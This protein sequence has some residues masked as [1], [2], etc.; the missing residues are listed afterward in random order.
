[1]RAITLDGFER[2]FAADPDP[3]QT[4]R[5]RDEA[6]KRQAILHAIG[7]GPLGRILELAA[8][9]GSNS[10]AV[11]PRA[12][13]LDA[14]EATAA[15]TTLVAKALAGTARARAI[16]LAVPARL[17]RATY[18]GVVV[19]ELLYYLSPRAMRRTA[20]D[21]A[22]VLRPGGTLVL[23]HHRIDFHDF[24]QHAAPLHRQFLHATGCDWRVRPVH[25]NRR[26]AVLACIRA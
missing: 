21:V 26:W 11:A 14:T 10:V 23:A 16:R 13:R 4:F 18:D 2:T 19:A 15:G 17:P 25:R 24:A 20:C 3:W 8:G 9:N 6:V 5:N 7:P 1:M 12:L 22:G